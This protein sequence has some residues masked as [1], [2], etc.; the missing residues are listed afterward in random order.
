MKVDKTGAVRILPSSI[1]VSTAMS[2]NLVDG[3]GILL[4][5]LISFGCKGPSKI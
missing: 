5:A 1:P 4:T 2:P 3:Q